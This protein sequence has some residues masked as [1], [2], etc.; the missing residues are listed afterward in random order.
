MAL[1]PK[2][3][4]AEERRMLDLSA[5]GLV[6]ELRD[7]R[8]LLRQFRSDCEDVEDRVRALVAEFH[9]RTGETE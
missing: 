1:D 5:D 9:R 6:D 4:E 2:D 8:T 3:P 7:A